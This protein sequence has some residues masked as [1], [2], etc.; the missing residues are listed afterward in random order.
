MVRK[1][2]LFGKLGE[3]LNPSTDIINLNIEFG[4]YND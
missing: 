1:G 2:P 3:H 4:G